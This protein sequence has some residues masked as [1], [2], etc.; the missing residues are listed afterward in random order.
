MN[1][2]PIPVYLS[3]FTPDLPNDYGSKIPWKEGECVVIRSVLGRPD[4]FARMTDA[5]LKWHDRAP[6]I[7]S[8]RGR[9][10]WVYEVVLDGET[11]PTAIS[12][13]QFKFAPSSEPETK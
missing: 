10:R 13:A 9:G 5:Q 4:T 11:L 7:D 2:A 12:A 1:T 8:A 6:E 3:R